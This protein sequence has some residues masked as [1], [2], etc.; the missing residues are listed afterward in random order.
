M[1][2]LALAFAPLA[3]FA[4]P[5]FA[6]PDA[7][8]DHAMGAAPMSDHAMKPMS[9]ADKRAMAKCQKMK[10]EMAAKNARCAKL[11]MP[12]HV[13]AKPAMDHAM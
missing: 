9:A 2:K 13:M 7:M 3:L 10:P 11:M 4:A 5:V 6:A 12:S 1:I 8:A